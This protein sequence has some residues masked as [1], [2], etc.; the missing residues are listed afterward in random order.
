MFEKLSILFLFHLLLPLR[1]AH[2]APTTSIDALTVHL[3]HNDD[4]DDERDI[5]ISVSGHGWD[6]RWDQL[7]TAV[8]IW[9]V[10]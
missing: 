8:R 3:A 10:N 9:S 6:S 1:V 5:T 4:A 2:A 7:A